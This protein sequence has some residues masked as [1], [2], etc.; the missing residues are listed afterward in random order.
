MKWLAT[1]LAV[2]LF[3]LCVPPV[4][5]VIEDLRRDVPTLGYADPAGVDTVRAR[6]LFAALFEGKETVAS[7]R[8]AATRLGFALVEWSEG[9]EDFVF[10][11]ESRENAKG[12]GAYA[13]RRH[14]A[15]PIAIEAPHAED[16]AHTGFLAERLFLE[17]KPAA[18]AWN[19]APRDT[20]IPGN[21][22]S[23]DLA[24]LDE[25]VFQAFTRAFIE[26]Y[27]QGRLIQLHGFDKAKRKTPAAARCGVIVSNGSR[28]PSAWLSEAARCL[29]SALRDSVCV[30]P[31]DASELGATTNCQ[32]K[33]FR[34]AAHDGFL[35]VEMDLE[36]RLALRA[37]RELRGALWACLVPSTPA[38]RE[39]A[40]GDSK[41]GHGRNSNPVEKQP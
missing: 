6:S 25:S 33:L 17:G 37:D 13:F 41:D 3:A 12:W 14:V 39:S 24:H 8:P 31:L 10:V 2:G 34:E 21:G 26:A 5:T 4:P 35:H 11:K 16:D 40:A 18:A 36:A 20:L 30:Y 22:D 9:G 23:A 32:A 38:P 15:E 28:R 29:E 19:S 1:I 27:P 7:L